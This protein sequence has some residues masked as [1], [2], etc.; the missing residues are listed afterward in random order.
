MNKE[1]NAAFSV[2]K[3]KDDQ[4]WQDELENLRA[5]GHPEAERLVALARAYSEE[6]RESR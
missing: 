3:E 1:A 2:A 5:C 6:L 4:Y